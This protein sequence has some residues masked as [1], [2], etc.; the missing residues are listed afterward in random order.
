MV[1]STMGRARIVRLPTAADRVAIG[2]PKIADYTVINSKELYVLGKS[3]GST[4]LTYW[5]KAGKS[6]SMVINVGV[7]VEPLALTL[8][9]VLP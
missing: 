6:S 3:V 2:D 1:Q 9:Q 7:D 4:S 5:D 8:S